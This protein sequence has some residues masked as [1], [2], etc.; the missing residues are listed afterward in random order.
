MRTLAW[1]V[2]IV[3]GNYAT[4]EVGS[5]DE[6]LR[7]VAVLSQTLRGERPAAADY[8]VD[9]PI[10]ERGFDPQSLLSAAARWCPGLIV[11]ADSIPA[12][13][14]EIVATVRVARR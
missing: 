4:V 8:G 5:D 13:R 10:G 14:R 11:D 9:D 12:D 3:D 6:A 1:P 2:R 7:N